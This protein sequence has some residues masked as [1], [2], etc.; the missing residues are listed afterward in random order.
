M[1]ASSVGARVVSSLFV[2]LHELNSPYKQV[3]WQPGGAVVSSRTKG[4]DLGVGAL[5]RDPVMGLGS[6]PAAKGPCWRSPRASQ[7]GL[8][9]DPTLSF[10]RCET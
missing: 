1:G 9:S 6:H 10:A 8:S 7:V 5:G 4:G 2:F 3:K